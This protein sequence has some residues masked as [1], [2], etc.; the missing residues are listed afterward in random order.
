MFTPREKGASYHIYTISVSLFI[1]SAHS[2]NC[3]WGREELCICVKLLR[4]MSDK[5]WQ[6]GCQCFVLCVDGILAFSPAWKC[7]QFSSDWLPLCDK[8]AGYFLTTKH[9]INMLHPSQTEN[10]SIVCPSIRLSY[11][12]R[13]FLVSNIFSNTCTKQITLL[14]IC[15]F[16]IN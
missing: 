1:V 14:D 3:D 13:V 7:P 11:N 9:P 12:I 2:H 10:G 6:R 5:A 16:L 15:Y 8:I 4:L